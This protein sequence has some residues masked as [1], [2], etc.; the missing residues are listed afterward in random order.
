[1]KI[2]GLKPVFDII[3]SGGEPL[4][5]AGPCSAESEAQTLETAK[6]LAAAGIKIFR[7][8]VWKPRTKPGGFEGI[9]SE[10]LPWLGKVKESTGM[11]VVTEVA[12]PLHLLEAV[13]AGVDGV[14]IGA[15]TATNPFAVQE[16]ADTFSSL[17]PELKEKLT[18]LLKNPVNPDLELWIGA[19]ERIYGAGMRRIGAVHR[20]FSSYGR[21]LY[22]NR[23]RWAIPFE[24]QRR[25]PEL[26]VI[27]DPS[28]VGGRSDLVGS[29]AQQALDMKFAGLMIEAHCSPEKALS[30]ASQQV[31]P[32]ELKTI[33]SSLVCRHTSTSAESLDELRGQIDRVDEELLELLARRM[34]IS[35][36]IGDYK[37]QNKIPVIQPERYNMLMEKRVSDG[38]RLNLTPEFTRA[39][40]SLI[41]EESVRNQLEKGA[42]E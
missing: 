24:L 42:K 10:A 13:E 14:W 34:N 41:H 8:G 6:G 16:L 7:A 5:I 22:R 1:M 17:S 11:Q 32:N 31:T 36:E 20:G 33:L 30:D 27:F 12:T 37:R 39:L 25:I 4:V 29:L 19:I 3:P 2:T 40:L 35:R 23:P 21:H 15:R 18:V 28:H 38:E 26:P 9:G